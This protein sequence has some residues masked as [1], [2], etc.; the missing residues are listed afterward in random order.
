M[1]RETHCSYAPLIDSA[2]CLYLEIPEQRRVHLDL[3]FLYKLLAGNI[4]CP[5]ILGRFSF[6]TPT[7]TTRSESV[8]YFSFLVTIYAC[9]TPSSCN[10]IMKSVNDLEID[11]FT[12]SNSY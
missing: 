3:Y 7:H 11:M 8:F 1:L 9:N 4:D 5:Y 6:Y 10:R 12:S 2:P